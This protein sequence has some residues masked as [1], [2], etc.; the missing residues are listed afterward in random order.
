MQTPW[1]RMLDRFV[2]LYGQ[3]IGLFLAKRVGAKIRRF[4]LSCANNWRIA[5]KHNPKEVSN[6]HKLRRSG[7]C[8]SFDTEI[9]HYKSGTVFLF[10]FNYGH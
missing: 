2:N 1:H 7:C 9:T 3:E 8:G 10:G 5:R 6:Y 4:D